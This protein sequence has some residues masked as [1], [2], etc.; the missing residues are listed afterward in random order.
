MQDEIILS[1]DFS[2]NYD[3]KQHHEIQSAYFGHEAFTLYTAACYYRS[4]DFDGACVDRDAGL[5]VLSV[6]I[7][8]NETIHEGNIAF[9]CNNETF[10]NCLTAYTN[11]QKSLFLE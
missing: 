3:D 7:V 2:K 1:V 5:K 6:V 10:T 4:H 9:S 8:S 11:P